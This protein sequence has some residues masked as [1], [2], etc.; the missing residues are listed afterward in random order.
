MR[1]HRAVLVPALSLLLMAAV[2]VG[3]HAQ[4][5][6]PQKTPDVQFVP[7]AESIVIKMLEMAKVTKT[8]HVIDLGSGDG[9]IVITAAKR[10]GARGMGVEIDPA[11]VQRARE[12]A[13]A[14]G[15]ADR[16]T[17]VEGDLFEANI[18]DATV[19]TMYLLPDLNMRLRP[20][21]LSDL[22]P[23]TR[24]VSHNYDLGD[25]KPAQ[26]ATVT[27]NGTQH[28]VYFWV[29]PPRAAGTK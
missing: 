8:D 2:A 11:L 20:K 25:W 13:Q 3:V 22:K 28:T 26:T 9:R 18:R 12:N 6:A 17:F 14:A 24:I 10:Y 27:V 29:V 16:A 19:I 7:T 4:T 1:S 21:L 5:A 15:V 23:G